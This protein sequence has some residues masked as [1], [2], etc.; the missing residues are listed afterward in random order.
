MGFQCVDLNTMKPVWLRDVSDDTN[1]TTILEETEDG[2][3]LYTA[4]EVDH[5][6]DTISLGSNVEASSAAYDDML[7]VGTRGRTIWGIKIE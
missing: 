2:V 3:F 7:V 4:C 6:L 5:Q 1:S